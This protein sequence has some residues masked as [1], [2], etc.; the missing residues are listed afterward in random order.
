[1]VEE[2]AVTKVLFS[3]FASVFEVA[4]GLNAALSV[5][6]TA[7]N[8]SLNKFDKAA[9]DLIDTELVSKLEL[10]EESATVARLTK[11]KNEEF[12][13]ISRV[14]SIG[15]WFSMVLAVLCGVLLILIGIYSE[16][17]VSP[18]L[19]GSIAFICIATSPFYMWFSSVFGRRK[20]KTFE[21]Q[22]T[23]AVTDCNTGSLSPVN[24]TKAHSQLQSKIKKQ[25][26]KS[27]IENEI[28]ITLPETSQTH[29]I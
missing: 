28:E 14:L 26:S 13:S 19:G 5:W 29:R 7:R 23:D 18:L 24:V 11:T 4:F 25:N 1:M 16:Y 21:K 3:G 27:T 10:S 2:V 6:K 8:E 15:K 22:C 20:L 9:K 12:K 17:K